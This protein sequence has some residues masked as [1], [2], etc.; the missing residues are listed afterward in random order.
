MANTRS[1]SRTKVGSEFDGHSK[2]SGSP[3]CRGLAVL[4]LDS[5]GSSFWESHDL[6]NAVVSQAVPGEF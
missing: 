1:N 4:P 5:A 6:W 3:V 2:R